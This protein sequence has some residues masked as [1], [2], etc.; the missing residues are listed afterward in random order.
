MEKWKYSMIKINWNNFCPPVQLSIR[1][2]K[3]QFSQEKVIYITGRN[4]P[5]ILH[6]KRNHHHNNKVVGI[7]RYFSLVSLNISGLNFPSKKKHS[8]TDLVYKTGFIFLLHPK[9]HTLPLRISITLGWKDRKGIPSKWNQELSMC[10]SFYIWQTYF[11]PILIRKN[12][13]GYYI[14]MIENVHQEDIIILY[15]YTPRQGTFK[16]VKEATTKITKWP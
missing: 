9:K 2:C 7:N 1:H 12:R 13:N 5:R 14:L 6:Q 15:I 3:E 10:I 8:L 4:N 11:K 16:F